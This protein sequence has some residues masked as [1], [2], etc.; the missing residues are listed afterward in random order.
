MK[1]DASFN[2]NFIS[3][4]AVEELWNT[5]QNALK[6]LQVA[7]PRDRRNLEAWYLEQETALK[8]L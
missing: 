4:A 2:S 7:I 8:R 3:L 1:C 5:A 6:A